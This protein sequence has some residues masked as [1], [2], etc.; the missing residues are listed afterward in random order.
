MEGIK[1]NSKNQNTDSD[2]ESQDTTQNVIREVKDMI[3]ETFRNMYEE[4]RTEE[5]P[6]TA[7]QIILKYAKNILYEITDEN[8]IFK[9]TVKNAVR[10][11]EE[12]KDD[13]NRTESD[14]EPTAEE[15]EYN[16]FEDNRYGT[17]ADNLV[18]RD[19][20]LT[21]DT[22]RALVEY[23]DK[24]N[25]YLSEATTEK[26]YRLFEFRN[27]DVYE[28]DDDHEAPKSSFYK[29]EEKTGY[30]MRDLGYE[31][32]G[33]RTE[34]DS[35]NEEGEEYLLFYENNREEAE[36][37]ILEMLGVSSEYIQTLIENDEYLSEYISD[38]VN[39]RVRCLY[40]NKETE[41]FDYDINGAILYYG[42][43]DDKISQVIEEM[44]GSD[45]DSDSN[46]EAEEWEQLE[47]P[48]PD[49]EY[50]KEQEEAKEWNE[51]HKA[52][53]CPDILNYDF[54]EDVEIC[55]IT[56]EKIEVK[57]T[58]LCNHDF[59]FLPFCEMLKNDI[60]ECPL[61]RKELYN[62]PF[63]ILGN[64]YMD[65]CEEIQNDF[66]EGFENIFN[67]YMDTKPPPP[68]PKKKGRPAKKIIKRTY[69]DW[70]DIIENQDNYYNDVV[71]LPANYAGIKIGNK[72]DVIKS[73]IRNKTH[74]RKTSNNSLLYVSHHA[75]TNIY[76]YN[77][78]IGVHNTHDDKFYVFNYLK[79]S[80]TT[81]QHTCNLI[82]QLKDAGEDVMIC[83][84]H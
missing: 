75:E 24:L 20:N 72:N 15:K 42:R 65:R 16:D 8:K 71:Y 50:I 35:D 34:T 33:D 38:A 19:L 76:S 27:N 49:E 7:E 23:D 5:E 81:R 80:N 4:G 11:Q 55:P 36:E 46:S 2:T 9:R 59:D 69:N 13:A 67:L 3:Y 48:I 63:V 56:Q 12:K 47:P 74:N 70:T 18:F 58:T 82:R 54:S 14:E 31:E 39:E 43:L 17:T 51:K 10:I 44:N 1:F 64:M 29:L 30:A 77:L 6:N 62:D 26:L 21:L 37:K 52:Q 32:D 22:W 73:F 61:C 66:I 25:E 40:D 79:Q 57:Y 68:A 45:S 41:N 84:I 83:D 53:I 60:D 28:Y 78:K